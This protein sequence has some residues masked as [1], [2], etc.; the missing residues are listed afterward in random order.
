ME[1]LPF[2]YK[3]TRVCTRCVMDDTVPGISFDSEGVCDLCKIH[4]NLEVKYRLDE[5]SKKK[6]NE[7]IE[8]IKKDG[9]NKK[10]DCIVGISGGRDSTYTLYSAIRLGLRPLAVH[11]DNGWNTDTAVKNIKSICKRLDVDLH[12]H[13]ANWEE[14]KDLQ[15]SFLKA[16]VS[17]ADVPTDWVIFSVLFKEAA[18]EGLKYIIHG[19]SFRTEGTTP[20]TW[21]YMDGRYVRDV[22]SKYGTLKI[23]SF[24]VMTL[25]DFVYFSFIKG[26]KQIRLLYYLPYAEG[27]VLDLL[28]REVGWENYGG[29]HHESTYTSFFQSYFLTRKFNIDKRKLHFS[30][31]IRSGQLNRLDA[32]DELYRDPYVEGE[33]SIRYCLKKLNFSE[34]DFSKI[35]QDP[36]K[37]FT[38]YK[39]YFHLVQKFKG[40]ILIGE[41]VGLVP[42]TVVNKF[43]NLK[44]KSEK[45]A[46]KRSAGTSR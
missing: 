15:R 28:A 33:E 46:S 42:S 16:S 39:T 9:R 7:I 24:P 8:K 29:K 3:A 44:L 18:K 4:D 31:L 10:Y 19:H 14:F 1:I 26:I 41:R 35:M 37:S 36:K 32:V 25:L 34:Q 12:T 2:E 30:A 20:L 21:T 6:L 5:E 27:E 23:R 43:F 38:D 13:V 11:F 40:L 45:G 22:Q 17:D